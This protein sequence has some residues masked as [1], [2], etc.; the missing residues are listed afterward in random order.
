MTFKGP[1]RDVGRAL[2]GLVQLEGMKPR[3]PDELGDGERCQAAGCHSRD[4][5]LDGDRDVWLCGYHTGV[6]APSP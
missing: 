6:F 1:N 3:R 2:A 5:V 4:T